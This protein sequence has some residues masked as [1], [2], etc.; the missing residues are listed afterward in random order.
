[1]EKDKQKRIMRELDTTDEEA[2][3]WKVKVARYIAF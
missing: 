1:M 2:N 3:N